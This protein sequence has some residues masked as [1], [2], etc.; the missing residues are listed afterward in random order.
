MNNINIDDINMSNIRQRNQLRI[1][2][3]ARMS[4]PVTNNNFPET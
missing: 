1:R 4:A 3:I 2:R